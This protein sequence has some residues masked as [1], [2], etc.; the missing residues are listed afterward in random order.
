MESVQEKESKEQGATRVETR[1][2][3]NLEGI[4]R[5]AEDFERHKRFPR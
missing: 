4:Q 1:G 5:P 2:Q 3:K